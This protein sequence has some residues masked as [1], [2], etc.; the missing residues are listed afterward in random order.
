M[1]F[2]AYEK[3]RGAEKVLAMR[4]GESFGVFFDEV[5]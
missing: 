5:A 4:K 1:K 2:N 3:G